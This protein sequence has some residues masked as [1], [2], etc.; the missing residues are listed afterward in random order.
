M[1]ANR[2]IQGAGYKT[3]DLLTYLLRFLCVCVFYWGQFVLEG[4]VLFVFLV[5]SAWKDLPEMTCC[6]SGVMLNSTHSVTC[7][8]VTCIDVNSPC[9]RD[10]D[11]CVVVG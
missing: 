7:G 5:V 6:V 1:L 8:V 3:A 10:C 2:R 11:V 9:A 4:K